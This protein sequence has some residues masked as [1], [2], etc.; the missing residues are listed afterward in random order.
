MFADRLDNELEIPKIRV[1]SYYA[2]SFVVRNCNFISVFL[3]LL[4]MSTQELGS[5]IV[6]SDN[7]FG[8][9]ALCS[10]VKITDAS[11]TMI[12]NNSFENCRVW[13]SVLDIQVQNHSIT[14][15]NNSFV[16]LNSMSLQR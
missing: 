16:N 8:N 10:V 6:I 9:S 3:D 2:S 13:S 7:V 14:V 15:L 5:E 4:S 11:C 1:S 12:A